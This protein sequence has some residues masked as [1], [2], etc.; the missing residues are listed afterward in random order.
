M[1]NAFGEDSRIL[2]GKL[3]DTAGTEAYI[4]PVAADFDVRARGVEVSGLAVEFDEDDSKYATGDHTH[5]ENVAGKEPMSFKFYCKAVQGE[6]T[7]V[8]EAYVGNFPMSK[9]IQSAGH[10]VVFDATAGTWTFTPSKGYDAVTI[11]ESVI[12]RDAVSGD[13]IEYRLSGGMSEMTLEADGVGKPF[14]FNFSTKGKVQDV[15][16]ISDTAIPEL[17]DDK[18]IDTVAFTNVNTDITVEV[19]T[20]AGIPT[21]VTHSFCS[22]SFTFAP[23]PALSEQECQG[24]NSGILYNYITKRSPVISINPSLELL[25]DYNFWTSLTT[26]TKY[27][28]TITKYTD[29]AKDVKMMELIMPNCQQNAA[30]PTAGDGKI[31]NAL[32]FRAMRNLQGATQELKENDYTLVIYGKDID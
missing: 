9:Y 28:I 19:L 21:A 22:N 27:K 6:L 24:E 8:D 10:K 5:D 20:D 14:K 2:L 30:A 7:T 29:A 26:M 12:D 17:D 3:E 32:T 13:G 4:A 11:T 1:G 15:V 23:T 25:S 31:R 16:E 18:I